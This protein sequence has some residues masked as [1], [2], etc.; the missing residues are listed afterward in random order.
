MKKVEWDIL[1]PPSYS[2]EVLNT[3]HAR[4][5]TEGP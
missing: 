3:L 4:W 1:F 2:I 5:Q